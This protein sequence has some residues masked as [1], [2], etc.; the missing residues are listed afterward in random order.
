MDSACA[1]DQLE[2]LQVFCSVPFDAIEVHCPSDQDAY[3]VCTNVGSV[4]DAVG[5][6]V[7]SEVGSDVGWAVGSAVGDAV[8]VCVGDGVGV[9]VG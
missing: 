8:G 2:V 9:C 3:E 6:G 5:T 4:G 7:G 1:S